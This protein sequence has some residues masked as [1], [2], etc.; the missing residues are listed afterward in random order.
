MKGN[1]ICFSFSVNIANSDSSM[2]RC[3]EDLT[4]NVSISVSLIDYL[5]S[6][7]WRLSF[8]PSNMKKNTVERHEIVLFHLVWLTSSFDLFNTPPL[9]GAKLRWG[10]IYYKR[11]EYTFIR[12][13]SD[14]MRE[15]EKQDRIEN[16]ILFL[17][18]NMYNSQQKKVTT[19]FISHI[20]RMMKKENWTIDEFMKELGFESVHRSCCCV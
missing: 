17:E 11:F 20:N 16:F 3:G 19:A 14:D 8:L 4:E 15:E 18:A 12:Y 10:R 7:C 9:N 13:W 1:N 2:V 5:N 6:M